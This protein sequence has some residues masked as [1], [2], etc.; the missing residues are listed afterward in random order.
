MCRLKAASIWD[1]GHAAS[2]YYHGISLGRF[3]RSTEPRRRRRQW[4]SRDAAPV[5][6]DMGAE[7]AA[8]AIPE[9]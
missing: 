7:G 1:K 2:H 4:P 8:N 5:N 3:F 9:R 6:R